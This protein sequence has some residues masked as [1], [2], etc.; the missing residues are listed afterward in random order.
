MRQSRA[1]LA[2][3]LASFLCAAMTVGR[4]AYTGR[5]T[6]IFFCWNLFL[7]WVPLGLALALARY[8]A[9][10]TAG[11]A[12]SWALGAAWLVFFPNAPYL[13]T[14]LVHLRARSP[15]PVWFDA[16]LVFGFALTGLCLAFVS[17]RLVHDL[18]ERR[19][20][21]RAGWCFVTLVAGLTGVGIYLGRFLRWNSWDL[22]TRP[23]EL[24]A[25]ASAW[26]LHPAAHLGSLSVAAAFGGSFGV[27]YLLLCALTHRPQSAPASVGQ[28][29]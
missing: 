10:G 28:W 19:R 21:P 3:L 17:L 1:L 23:G 13:V 16:L 29:G 15:V 11:R 20:G 27:S 7:A 5:G 24:V 8:H 25:E 2:L 26:V 6:F 12:G 18:V 22:V 9:R 14:D 4:V